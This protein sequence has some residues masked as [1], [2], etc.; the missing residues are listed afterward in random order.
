MWAQGT[1]VR[2]SD[3]KRGH[4]SVWSTIDDWVCVNASREVR[5]S[6]EDLRVDEG[7]Q[8]PG[9]N[10]TMTVAAGVH[11]EGSADRRQLRFSSA[12]G[13]FLQTGEKKYGGMKKEDL[14]AKFMARFIVEA[15]AERQRRQIAEHPQQLE[16]AKVDQQR[17]VT[18]TA[19]GPTNA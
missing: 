7:W 9:D 1:L 17:G 12:A 14:T 15:T 16:A 3:P 13:A 11:R 4:V 18:V 2:S 10:G 19:P 6:G 8:P 5:E